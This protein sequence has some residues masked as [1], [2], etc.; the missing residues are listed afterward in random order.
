MYNIIVK[1]DKGKENEMV[2]PHY[3]SD[4]HA[5]VLQ[6]TKDYIDDQGQWYIDTDKDFDEFFE[7][8]WTVD[9]VTGNGSGSY[10]FN[11]AKARDAVSEFIFSDEFK[12]MCDEWC[13]DTAKLI[14]DGPEAVDVTIRCYTLGFIEQEA[15]DYWNEKFGIEE[16]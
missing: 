7:N 6:D 15:H 8:L 2:S 12:D 5:E 1:R 14:N 10:Y 9:S 3:A 16:D 13:L 4:Y 11:S